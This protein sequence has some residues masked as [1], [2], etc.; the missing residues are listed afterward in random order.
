MFDFT[1]PLSWYKIIFMF[2]L[3]ISEGLITYMLKHRK[4]FALRVV[5]SAVLLAVV[6]FFMPVLSYSIVS[7]SLIFIVLF[8]L[9]VVALLVCF[10][11]PFQR[12]IFL[13]VLAYIGQHIAYVTVYFIVNISGLGTFAVY[14]SEEIEE[15]NPFSVIV[16]VCVYALVYWAEW[17][18]IG[19]QVRRTN[20]LRLKNASLI[21]VSFII[22]LFNVV[23]NTIVV[24]DIRQSATKLILFVLYIYDL[25]SC[26]LAI[27]IQFFIMRSIFLNNEVHVIRDLWDKDRELY[28]LKKEQAEIINVKCHDIKHRLREFG[29]Q[30]HMDGDAVRQMV[31]T[32][33]IYDSIFSTG[34]E[35]LDVILSEEAMYCNKRGIQLI[36]DVDGSCLGFVAESDLFS[37]FENAIQ[38]AVEAAGEVSD[39]EKRMIKIK[40]RPMSGFVSV[41]IENNFA[42]GREIAFKD[43]LPISSKPDKNEHGFGMRSIQMVTDKYSGG[44]NIAVEGDVFALDILIPLPEERGTEV[45]Q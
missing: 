20:D 18:F 42:A 26:V 16:Y 11:E 30:L 2:E 27:G 5:C 31:D 4:H 25:L 32:I 41:H 15:I 28:E 22:L 40:V 14:S 35:V 13:A 19:Y 12:I 37:L 9:S 36:C 29:E 8:V 1:A 34:S 45:G 21:S 33:K 7:I 38:N 17:A 44:M 6:A 39:P 43:D 3:L 10:D 23:L 24:H